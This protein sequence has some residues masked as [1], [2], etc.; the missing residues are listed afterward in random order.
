MNQSVKEHN[1][2]F[3]DNNQLSDFYTAGTSV[4]NRPYLYNLY[5]SKYRTR[6]EVYHLSMKVNL[7]GKIV[8][9]LGCGTGRL[10]LEFA[11]KAKKVVGIDFAQAL[12]DTANQE[13]ERRK[14]HN[15]EFHTCA[16]QDLDIKEKF[17]VVYF[18]GVLMCIEDEDCFGIIQDIMTVT[19]SKTII[20]NRDTIAYKERHTTKSL[21]NR[22]DF[23]VYRTSEEYLRLF[24]NT[25][26]TFYQSEVIPWVIGL[27]AYYKLPKSWQSNRLVLGILS[28]SLRIQ[29]LLLDPFFLRN[30]WMYKRIASTWE[31]DGNAKRQFYF[32][33]KV[34][35]L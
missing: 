16:L 35:E 32:M 33:H 18:G 4:N 27:T 6:V 13:K 5:F 34:K 14:L 7:K 25:A 30:K 24:K 21:E 20:V 8:L 9:D 19:H 17:D 1:K 26:N 15:V 2:E 10:T 22:N 3:W 23:A 31:V 28:I 12:I 29:S 11:K